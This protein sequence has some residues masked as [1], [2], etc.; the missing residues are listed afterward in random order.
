MLYA[1]PH[2]IEVDTVRGRPQS[3]STLPIPPRWAFRHP[4]LL[5]GRKAVFEVLLCAQ[6]SLTHDK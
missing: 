2:G 6:L 4:L 1:L 3:Y 5:L